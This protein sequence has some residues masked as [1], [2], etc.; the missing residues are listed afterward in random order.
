[1]IHLCRLVHGHVHHQ[2][3]LLLILRIFLLCIHHGLDILFGLTP[4]FD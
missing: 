3:F 2:N 1:M 4:D